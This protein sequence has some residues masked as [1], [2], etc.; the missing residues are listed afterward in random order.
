M[1][2]HDAHAPTSVN[3]VLYSGFSH[4]GFTAAAGWNGRSGNSASR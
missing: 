2:M 3:R 4:R 1:E